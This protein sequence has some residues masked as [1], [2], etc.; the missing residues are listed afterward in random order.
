M[1]HGSISLFVCFVEYI[2]SCLCG[3]TRRLLH[4]A[5]ICQVLCTI[6]HYATAVKNLQF[7]LVRFA[8]CCGVNVEHSFR[9]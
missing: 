5:S 3:T 9:A 1:A 4:F 2:I 7:W 8:A 6:I